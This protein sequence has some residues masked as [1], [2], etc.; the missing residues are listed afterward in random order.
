MDDDVVYL[1]YKAYCTGQ[2]DVVIAV[3]MRN[4]TL[5]GFA[6]LDARRDFTLM[7]NCTSEISKYLSEDEGNFSY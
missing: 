7:R 6:K 2:T 1:L 4:Q 3:D 5:K